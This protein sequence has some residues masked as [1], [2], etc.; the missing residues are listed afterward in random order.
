MQVVNDLRQRLRVQVKKKKAA[1]TPYLALFFLLATNVC[2]YD[3]RPLCLGHTHIP[4][5]P[6]KKHAF[7]AAAQAQQQSSDELRAHKASMEAAGGPAHMGLQGL[8]G[9]HLDAMM[10]AGGKNS[11]K[12]SLCVC[13][14]VCVCMY[15][16]SIARA[17]PRPDV[18]GRQTF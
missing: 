2:T 18:R 15:V 12:F 6:K 1:A 3:A 5:P 7:C 9:L 8:Q 16:C 10:S 4:P 11:E 17:A 14:C 13:V